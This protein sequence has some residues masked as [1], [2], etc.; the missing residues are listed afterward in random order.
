M[1]LE[2]LKSEE[3]HM[4]LIMFL[5][6]L[7]IPIVAFVYVILFNN[8][9]LIDLVAISISFIS[10]LIKIFEKLLGSY[11]KYIYLAL[12]PA[13]SSII[14][15]IGNDGVF[16][17]FTEAYFLVLL[18]AISYYNLNAIK[19]VGIA[20]II[21]NAI[22]LI[23]RPEAY[24]KMRTFSIWIFILMVYVLALLVAMLVVTRTRKLFATVE[25][26]E[27][28]TKDLLS[29]VQQAF[30]S[31]EES[32][33]KIF[34]FLQEF[35]SNTEEIAN[36]T[37]EIVNSAN[38]QIS[39]VEGSLK[40]FGNLNNK[41]TSSEEQ[42]SQTVKIMK[43]LKEN[44]DEGIVAIQVLSKKFDENIRT[45]KTASNGITDL[46]HKSSFIGNIIE[47][48][49]EIAQQTNLLALNAAIEAARAG[50]AGKGF[51]VVAEE[52]NSLSTES[53]NA[54]SKI[55]AILKDIIKTI[56]DTH[57][58]IEHDSQVVDDSN[59][60]LNDMVKIFETMIEFFE[61]VINITQLL[62]NE[63]SDIVEIKEQLLCSMEKVEDISREFVKT[64]GEISLA[65]EGQVAGVSSIIKSMQNIQTG[66]EKLSNILHKDIED[67]IN[68]KNEVSKS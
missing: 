19:V 2:I 62:E 46:S 8:G 38:I 36:S 43:E 35:E 48:I 25:E 23:I 39:E 6:D 45:T 41:I 31:L 3:K 52:I 44:N 49:R 1:Q 21:P 56:E 34:N 54:T 5:F 40:I 28:E 66:M 63:L 42:V 14:I 61:K 53:S 16:G 30:D 33:A 13:V 50:E 47:S 17:A 4:N 10:I 12:I 15:V 32:S 20:T 68:N 27:H 64:T 22:G 65:T 58:S 9:S 29:G 18:L 26:K 59:K 7:I 67:N 24:L 57:K 60:K 51:A 11:A 37:Q 55:D